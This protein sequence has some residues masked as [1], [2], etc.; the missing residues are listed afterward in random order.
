VTACRWA[1]A[2]L[3]G[4]RIMPEW[5]WVLFWVLLVIVAL[6]AVVRLARRR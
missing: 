2:A 6:V 5:I 1:T 4:S 3:E